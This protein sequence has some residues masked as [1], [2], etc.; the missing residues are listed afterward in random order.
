MQRFP[1][2]LAAQYF[3]LRLFQL[4]TAC[5]N[6]LKNKI[7]VLGGTPPPLYLIITV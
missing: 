2:D 3:L 1:P 6:L 4:I 7:Y 5:A